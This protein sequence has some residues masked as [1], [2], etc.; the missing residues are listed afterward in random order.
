MSAA[1]AVG[2][3]RVMAQAEAMG[4]RPTEAMLSPT[5]ANPFVAEVEVV[6]P[7]GYVPGEYRWLRTPALVLR[8]AD[9]VPRLRIP[10]GVDPDTAATVLA[11][12]A[13][14]PDV[15]HY[16]VWSRYPYARL[17]REG[18]GWVARWSDARYDGG[19]G[20]G[21]LGGVAVRVP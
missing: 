20:S 14:E 21:G 4:L 2:A 16:L 10:E 11:A 15:R 19:E 12:A 5:A 6:T 7:A 8:P 3:R 17:S 1:S 18:D 9:V 13:A